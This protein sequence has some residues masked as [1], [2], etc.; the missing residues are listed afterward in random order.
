MLLAML[1]GL[2]SLIRY[3]EPYGLIL[4]LGALLVVLLIWGLYSARRTTRALAM[5]H[6]N[7]TKFRHLLET[8]P[9]V[10]V[11]G[12]DP[13]RRVIFWN[14]ASERLYGYRQDEA[15][16]RLLEELIVP[17]SIRSQHI[18]DLDRW[19]KEDQPLPDREL[20]RI[21]KDGSLVSVF[22]SHMMLSTGEGQR[23]IYHLDIDLSERK[24]AEAAL[25]QRDVLLDVAALTAS[26]LLKDPDPILAIATCFAALGQATGVSRVYLFKNHYCSRTGALLMSQ[27]HEWCAEN[28]SAEIDNPEL[29]NLPYDASGLD[30][31]RQLLTAHQPIAGLI[32]DF[33][34]PE[35]ILL[36]PQGIVTILVVPIDV[37]G[38]FWGFVGLDDCHHI[39]VWSTPEQNILQNIA[40][41]IGEAIA[42]QKAKAAL[43]ESEE[44]FRRITDNMRDLVWQ[45]D[46]S[47]TILYAS[48][49]FKTV[50][51]YES[52]T[53]LGCAISDRVHPEDLESTLAV[54]HK[55]LARCEANQVEFRYQ[56]ADGNYLWLEAIGNPLFDT[57]GQPIGAVISG[58]DITD[59]KQTEAD[60]RL[61]A[62]VFENSREAIIVTDPQTRILSVNRA[63]CDITGY[64]SN[65][66]MG[67]TPQ[68]LASGRHDR[69]FYQ[70]MWHS[71]V[72]VGHWQGEIW[73]RHKNGEIYPE[74]LG[75]SAVYDPQGQLTHYMGIFSDL[76]E[77]KASADQIDF[78]AHHDPLTALPNRLLLHD[79]LIRALSLAEHNRS[80]V[81]LLALDI[82]RFKLINDS[83]G[84]EL[85]D[86]LLQQV[87]LRLHRKLRETDTVSRQGS[88]EFLVLL[89]ETNR[90]GAE[91]VAN[92]LLNCL[93]NESWVVD[94]HSLNVT[95]S[96]GISLYPDHGQDG[97]TLLK[98]AGT[99]LRYA[100]NNGGNT[101]RFFANGM[102]VNTLER[103]QLETG[104]RL[105]LERGEFLLHYQPQINLANHCIV[106]AE[107]LL[108][109]RHPQKGLIPPNHFI[110]VAEDSG[111]I[112]PIG[113]WVLR[114]ACRQA[115]HW[116][117]AE[118]PHI[119]VAVNLSGLQM[120][121]SSLVETVTHALEESG[122]SP[123][124][125]ELELTES[126]LI[127]DVDSTLKTVQQLR[128]M[129]LKL[130]I[131]DFG[132]GY[133]CLSYLQKL[134][135]HT[136][137]ID[138][139]FV[140]GLP[141]NAD[142]AAIVHAIIQMAHSL[143]LI[144]VAEGVES[145]AE[146]H[147]LREQDCDHVQ[148]YYFSPPLPAEEFVAL[149]ARGPIHHPSSG[150]QH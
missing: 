31:W 70:E 40:N 1:A 106:G 99:A 102:N 112:V 25:A 2:S 53:L 77:R 59:R 78:L 87:A 150:T 50:L 97:D 149:L 60:L 125:L 41:N 32:R 39:R 122:L 148:G 48:P 93:R 76:S 72:T 17:P 36:E 11:Q 44:R 83:L 144:T 79:R 69:N 28:I 18:A 95:A 115:H 46:I 7:E 91:R 138:R 110:P 20:E 86:Q 6:A 68:M 23:E 81:S 96:V 136:L 73:N 114:E 124:R 13:D 55:L 29:Q 82:D 103:L 121:R 30:R 141:H 10:A 4:L 19:A 14:A 94:G 67:Q 49:S 38:D 61:A 12:C 111:L 62:Q 63:F 127:Q 131:D 118:L 26:R 117:Q 21:R 123:D 107:A 116:Q 133:S 85:G 34:E 145:E 58:R 146:L 92:N 134:A 98:K 33:P 74:W 142:S 9:N 8:I 45:S 54:F 37:H 52:Q 90:D 100:K 132:T 47:G 88:D 130:S 104:L 113:E 35:R 51:G 5:A 108:R 89:P 120:Q 84:H 128:A 105:A 27:C 16:G 64:S 43:Q 126:I 109:W 75:I 15:L 101:H 143:K 80:A 42:R 129:G 3:S 56:H 65:E 135:V 57:T 22:S 24:Q 137:K 139:S 147:F 119:T 140:R 71:V 66:V